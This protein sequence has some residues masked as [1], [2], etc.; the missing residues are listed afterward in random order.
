MSDR[1]KKPNFA[2]FMS[3]RMEKTNAVRTENTDKALKI[4][5]SHKKRFYHHR[6]RG[7][8]GLRVISGRMEKTNTV[9]N[10]NTGKAW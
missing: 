8:W 6:H 5:D 10:E 9:K 7:M 1:V 3:A 4:T 2:V